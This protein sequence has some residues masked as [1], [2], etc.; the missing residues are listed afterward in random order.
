MRKS[1][2]LL[3]LM[4]ISIIPSWAWK[5]EVKV[6]TPNM[7]LLLTSEEGQELRMAYFGAKTASLRELRDAGADINFPALP[8]FGT[9][10]MIHLP[11]ML[12]QQGLSYHSHTNGQNESIHTLIHTNAFRNNLLKIG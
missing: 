11:A 6:E 7:Q 1:M 9:V 3:G 5:G 12:F 2:I 8:A 4:A 10:D